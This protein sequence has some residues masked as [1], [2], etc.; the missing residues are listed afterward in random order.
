MK[1]LATLYLIGVLFASHASHCGQNDVTSYGYAVVHSDTLFGDIS[2][3][4]KAGHITVS[5][6]SIRRM[7]AYGIQQVTLLDGKRMTFIAR[8]IDGKNRFFQLLVDGN[9]Q[10]LK[11]ENQYFATIKG[12]LLPINE[13]ADLYAVFRRRTVKN[14]LYIRDL[15]LNKEPDIIDVFSYFNTNEAF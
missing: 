11:A 5:Q 10:L 4:F 15:D 9:Y 1:L 8:V 7:F 14:Y 3:N 6:D 2:V 12:Q 13:E